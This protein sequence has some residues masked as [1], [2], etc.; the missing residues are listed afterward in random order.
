MAWFNLVKPALAKPAFILDNF[1]R[2]LIHGAIDEVVETFTDG[3][4]I[5]FK[6]TAELLDKSKP[7]ENVLGF[8]CL[9]IDK[10]KSN[11]NVNWNSENISHF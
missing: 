4:M 3:E 10:M 11:Q 8:A 2:G 1:A 9:L 5:R 6:D 7:W